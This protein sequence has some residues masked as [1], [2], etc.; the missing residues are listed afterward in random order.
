MVSSSHFYKVEVPH[1]YTIY[2]MTVTAG[3]IT[4]NSLFYRTGIIFVADCKC[5]DTPNHYDGHFICKSADIPN[6]PA[7]HAKDRS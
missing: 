7:A 4:D 6:F 5:V 3:W 1:D 2:L